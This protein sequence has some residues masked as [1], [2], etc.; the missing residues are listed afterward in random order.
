MKNRRRS[1]RHTIVL[2]VWIRDPRGGER[3]ETADVSAHGVSVF[4]DEPRQPRQY[5]ELEIELPESEVVIA[6]TAMVARRAALVDPTTG[7]Q[8]PGMGLDFFLFDARSKMR[9]Q[10]FLQSF[11][12]IAPT[13]TPSDVVDDEVPAFLIRPRDVNRLWTF[14]NGELSRARIRIETAV[15]KPPGTVVEILV[16]H[17][18]SSA[19]WVLDGEVLTVSPPFR[20]THAVLEI[21]LPGIDDALKEAFRAFVAT[22]QDQVQ[23]EVSLSIEV[24]P[25]P[26][27][28]LPESE[29]SAERI[30]SVVV[31]FDQVPTLGTFDDDEPT[32][33]AQ[34][35]ALDRPDPL[36]E[37]VLPSGVSRPRPPSARQPVEP[38]LNSV[39][40]R[41]FAEAAAAEADVRDHALGTSEFL[42][43][44]TN[45][46]S[47]DG[48]DEKPD[49]EGLPRAI[50]LP[51]DR[52]R[53]N[54]TFGIRIKP[55]PADVR[56]GSHAAGRGGTVARMGSD[57]GIDREIAIARARVARSPGSIRASLELSRLL[58]ARGEHRWVDE[59]I[60][61]IRRV[62]AL[63]PDHPRAHHRLAELFA[64][65]GNYRLARAHLG[66]AKR[67]GYTVDPDLE[68]VVAGG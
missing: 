20:G 56:D 68:R 2:P 32:V 29:D 12:A 62:T 38:R 18:R 52:R 10:A 24:E 13:A 22:G 11:S 26:A 46:P 23:E 35:E 36:V 45:E 49:R 64:R 60:D 8:R 41:F 4:S 65:K 57:S 53:Q 54:D 47:H 25:E 1:G 17:P 30:E 51:V 15:A 40:A 66:Q 44:P 21:A 27:A 3:S 48:S 55:A 37:P 42:E 28:N 6:V 34:D 58:S 39:F 61:V 67:L 7:R 59:A 63:S 50:G 33:R 19:E 5:V 31:D 14:L 16:V 43:T 9:W